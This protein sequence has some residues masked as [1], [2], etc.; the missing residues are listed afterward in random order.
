MPRRISQSI[1]LTP[2]LDRFVQALVASG[3]YQTASEVVR[4]GLRLLQDRVGAPSHS[5]T[6]ISSP[7]SDH[8]A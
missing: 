3:R 6:G 5:A 1:S 8:E 4:D 2:E 7:D